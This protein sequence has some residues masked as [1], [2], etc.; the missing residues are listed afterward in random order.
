MYHHWCYK[1]VSLSSPNVFWYDNVF[2]RPDHKE[3]FLIL[4]TDKPNEFMSGT[5]KLKPS[6]VRANISSPQL[7]QSSMTRRI[8]MMVSLRRSRSAFPFPRPNSASPL[9]PL[10]QTPVSSRRS[11]VVLP[12]QP[13]HAPSATKSRPVPLKLGRVSS[14]SFESHVSVVRG[15]GRAPTLVLRLSPTD[16]PSSD[17]LAAMSANM[18]DTATISYVPDPM[19]FSVPEP[20]S[21]PL[22]RFTGEPSGYRFGS[23]ES[24]G[25]RSSWRRERSRLGISRPISSP[26]AVPPLPSRFSPA[27]IDE[28]MLL[29][30]PPPRRREPFTSSSTRPES[31]PEPTTSALA[32]IRPDSD[33]LGRQRSTR[34]RRATSTSTVG[35]MSIDWIMPENSTAATRFKGIG[36]APIRT[37]HATMSAVTVRS[38]VAIEHQESAGETLRESGS[39]GGGLRRERAR[40]DSGVLGVDDLAHVRRSVQTIS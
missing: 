33:V 37:T 38:S 9:A 11:S 3:E 25:S 32:G 27:S 2:S 12:D 10:E 31:E 24:E 13:T 21:A 28:S 20:H 29:Y 5:R 23:P 6:D 14:T 18:T 35:D 19:P 40:R 34:S 16:L 4:E 1:R 22:S 36:T 17:M 39:A 15:H 7:V 26:P 30:P 8:S